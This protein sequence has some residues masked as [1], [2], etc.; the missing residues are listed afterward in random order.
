M[1][2]A[3]FK[4]VFVDDKIRQQGLKQFLAKTYR[5]GTTD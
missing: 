4:G 3:R 2:V 1:I 5:I